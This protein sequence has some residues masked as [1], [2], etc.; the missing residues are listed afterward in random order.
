MTHEHARRLIYAA[1]ASF[2]DC[3]TLAAAEEKAKRFLGKTI[4]ALHDTEVTIKGNTVYRFLGATAMAAVATAGLLNFGDYKLFDVQDTCAN[5]F[6]WFRLVPNLEILT[7]CERVHPAIFEEAARVL[8]NTVIAPIYPLTD[9]KD[10]DFEVRGEID[11]TTAV[12]EFFRRAAK[13]PA[14]GSISSARDLQLAPQGF[15]VEH[16]AITPAIRPEWYFE[17]GDKNA[18]NALTPRKA[19]LAGATRMVI[20][21][22]LRKNGD[23]RGNAM[24]ALDEIGEALIELHGG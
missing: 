4:E 21:S 19:I 18:V 8:P 23:L 24:R 3:A 12:T 7:I 9:L 10:E 15:L 13:L 22:P 11:R 17:S 2:E 14:K 5:D 1:D 16:E 20:G 6:S